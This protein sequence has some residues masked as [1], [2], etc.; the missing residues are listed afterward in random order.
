MGSVFTRPTSFVEYERW[1][2]GALDI[3]LDSAVQGRYKTVAAAI[4]HEFETS[5]YWHEVLRS[6]PQFEDDYRR[7]S[8]YPL[9]AEE[10]RPFDVKPFQSFLH[11]T[12]RRNALQNRNW[13]D[14][15]PEGW[16]VPDGWFE[17]VRDIVRTLFVVKYLDGV[18]F[19]ADRLRS[20]A[21][22]LGHDSDVQFESKQEG[23]YAAHVYIRYP[24]TLPGLNWDSQTRPIWIELQITTQLQEVIRRLLHRHY[25][26]NRSRTITEPERHWQW[27][28]KGDEFAANYLGHILHY[29]EGMIMEVRE[30]QRE[31]E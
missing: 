19:L 28:Y 25:E 13:P 5:P 22:A 31:S 24:C 15:P 27:D 9:F 6:L 17:Q 1:L 29:I 30:R 10:V 20:A 14:P 3:E 21:A 4:Q 11:K 2:V 26:R 16:I 18:E 8:R 12:Y 23:Y 7:T